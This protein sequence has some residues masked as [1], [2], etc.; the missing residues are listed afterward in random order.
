MLGF[1]LYILTLSILSNR[2]SPRLLKETELVIGKKLPGLTPRALV[3]GA[4]LLE[5]VPFGDFLALGT[6]IQPSDSIRPTK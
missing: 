6:T 5:K 4:R 1:T 2:E 3:L